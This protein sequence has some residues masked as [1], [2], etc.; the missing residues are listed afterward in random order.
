MATIIDRCMKK[1]RADPATAQR[2]ERDRVARETAQRIAVLRRI[3]FRNAAHN[4]GV[5][6]LKNEHAAAELL[7]SAS[8]NADSFLVLGIL[9]MAVD[10]RW[11]EVVRAGIRHFGDHPVSARIQELWELT[12][13]TDRSAD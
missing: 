2:I 10:H 12:I 13:T 1:F 6:G 4:R 5:A 11:K 8:N 7:T 9:Q 3:V